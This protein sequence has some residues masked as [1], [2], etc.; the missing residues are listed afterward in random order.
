MGEI[1]AILTELIAAGADINA[2]S[3]LGW[4]LLHCISDQYGH[5]ELIQGIVRAG[6]DV[7]AK[8]HA[9]LT[10]LH[11]SVGR[12]RS[13]CLA[14]ELIAN[15]A[16]I[17]AEDA[18]D[19]TPMD[20]VFEGYEDGWPYSKTC[21]DIDALASAGARL[22]T[23]RRDIHGWTPLHKA[24]IA[25]TWTLAILC[26]THGADINERD[27]RGRTAL[28]IAFA[29][30]TSETLTSGFWE[31]LAHPPTSG[32]SE[33]ISLCSNLLKLGLDASAKTM[34]GLTALHVAA[35]AG[36]YGPMERMVALGAKLDERDHLGRTPLY[37]AAAQ[38]Y[39]TVVYKLLSLG[40]NARI[41]DNLGISP[42]QRAC[43]GKY[44]TS[45]AT[46]RILRAHLQGANESS[47]S[48]ISETNHISE[49]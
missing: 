38:G 13:R 9:G 34:T 18:K 4:T 27:E 48:C 31:P 47:C 2:K 8:D 45:S 35:D 3:H 40:A 30:S 32:S 25:D 12:A 20:I 37:F 24:I 42:L 7:N 23:T 15:G 22:D 26:A 5:G 43:K 16:D 39:K 46:A 11:H 44:A 21:Q 10:P 29:L 17:H 6:A 14:K 33:R 49:N 28:H 19:R 1:I 36:I 41:R